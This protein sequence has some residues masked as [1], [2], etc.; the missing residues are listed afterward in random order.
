MSA[1]PRVPNK[2]GDNKFPFLSNFETGIT[3]FAGGGQSSATQLGAQVNM[4]TVVA[5]D[6][7][8]VKL[9]KIVAEPGRLD[10]AGASVGT[11]LVLCNGDS[12]QSLQVFGATPDTIN[13]VATGT[14]VA[15]GA[16]LNAF[17]VAL[18]Y[19]QSTGV[20]RWRMAN[21][22][23]AA[24][25]AIT[26]GTIAGV[27]IENSAI[28]AVTPAAVTATNL[29]STELF[30]IGGIET[31]LT[32]FAGGGQASAL[33]LDATESI[34]NVTT[35][36]SAADSVKLPAAT[37]SGA[38]HWVKNSAAANSLQL[39][40]QATETIDGVASA[41][42]VSVAAGKSRICVDIAAGLWVSI[43]GA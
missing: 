3:A 16:G 28:G 35:V 15:M 42:G 10:P 40:G 26:S 33:A 18:D 13:G 43:L 19:T 22:M 2:I 30:S 9:P 7:D 20:G 8:S 39:F 37:G 24:V 29:R 27:T 25:A 17:F 21:S 12:A 14:G 5:T 1:Q 6:A 31:G 38:F 41:T 4:V 34:H 23:A 36:G 11:I 32:A